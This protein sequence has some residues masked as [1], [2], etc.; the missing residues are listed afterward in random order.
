MIKYKKYLVVTENGRNVIV[1]VEQINRKKYPD[2]K[3]EYETLYSFMAKHFPKT[4]IA[5]VELLSDI[6]MVGYIQYNKDYKKE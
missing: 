6:P 3:N 2:L 1:K 5:Y 4:S